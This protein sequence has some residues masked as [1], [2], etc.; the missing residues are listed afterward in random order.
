M[1]AEEG[2]DPAA[3]SVFGRQSDKLVKY[4]KLQDME[5][6][7]ILIDD[8]ARERIEKRIM[9]MVRRTEIK[10]GR[11]DLIG[12]KPNCLVPPERKEYKKK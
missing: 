9:E 10:C 6:P 5:L 11:T 7:E 3:W 4:R 2:M 8:S 12:Y 1:Y